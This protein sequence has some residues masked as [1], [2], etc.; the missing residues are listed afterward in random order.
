MTVETVQINTI[1]P[2]PA[3][4]RK[5][6]DRNL[7]VIKGSLTRFGQQKPIVVDGRGIVI[8]GN[9][10][11]AAACELGWSHVQIVRTALTGSE[12]TAYAIADNRAADLAE[13]DDQSLA[14][15]LAALRAED[16][17]LAAAAGYSP[18]ELAA[19]LGSDTPA[20]QPT[21]PDEFPAFDESIPTE[22]QCP[23]CKY[24]WS[25]SSTPSDAA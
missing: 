15:V 13:W 5:H 14:E 23:R 11:Y 17:D 2:D 6:P 19:L 24:A 21:A 10:T 4:L 20:E 16:D 22:H 7:S 25:G 3:N 1:Q 8:A 18:D 9:G 12:A